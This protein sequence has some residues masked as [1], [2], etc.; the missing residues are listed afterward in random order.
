MRTN[1]LAQL[2]HPI[3]AAPMAGGPSTPALVAAVSGAGGLGFLA[4]GY[5]TPQRLARHIAETRQLTAQPFGVNVF[6]PGNAS[7]DT[8]AVDAYAQRLST[9][10]SRSGVSLGE[11]IGDDDWYS[12]K[13]A[14]LD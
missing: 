5:L 14:L 12:D 13:L 7:I 10:A 9:E 4:A 2:S 3:V 1:V 8:A 6:V 11:P